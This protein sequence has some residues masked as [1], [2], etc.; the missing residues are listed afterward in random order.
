MSSFKL[1]GNCAFSCNQ[2]VWNDLVTSFSILEL[3]LR[4]LY[5]VSEN[6]QNVLHPII[7]HSYKTTI[8]TCWK[9]RDL[10][11]LILIW[12]LQVYTLAVGS[13]DNQKKKGF[14]STNFIILIPFEKEV[15]LYNIS[16]LLFKWTE[17]MNTLAIGPFSR[18]SILFL[19]VRDQHAYL[20]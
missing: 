7:F 5:E 13:I 19:L 16:E 15:H 3:G 12:L 14:G 4:K 18:I 1:L 10:D 17:K 11:H 8:Y 9:H 6:M 2:K 20:Y